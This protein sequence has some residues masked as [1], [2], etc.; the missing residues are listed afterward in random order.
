M[1]IQRKCDKNQCGKQ[2]RV[3]EPNAKRNVVRKI[4]LYRK[5][6]YEDNDA[7]PYT[8]YEGEKRVKKKQTQEND[9][10]NPLEKKRV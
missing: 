1:L 10:K 6:K 5:R 9:D 3:H 7:L 4:N 2:K 8:Q